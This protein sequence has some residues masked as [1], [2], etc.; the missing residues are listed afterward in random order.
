MFVTWGIAIESTVRLEL[1]ISG[2][3]AY[4]AWMKR[5][6]SRP[7]MAKLLEQMAAML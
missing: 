3:G 1:D 2:F 6:T 5:M 4:H 7:A